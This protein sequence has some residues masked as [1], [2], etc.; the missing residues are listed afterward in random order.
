MSIQNWPELVIGLLGGG[1][2]GSLITFF[3]ARHDN[4]KERAS[5]FYQS[6]YNRLSEYNSALYGF[7]YDFIKNNA[8]ISDSIDASKTNESLIV[9]EVEN[10]NKD[11]NRFVRKCN[12][13]GGPIDDICTQCQKKREK[14]TTLY[15]SSYWETRLDSLKDCAASYS[16][17]AALL[18][19]GGIAKKSIRNAVNRVDVTSVSIIGYRKHD[20]KDEFDVSDV[21]ISQLENINA[22][23]KELS[24]VI[25]N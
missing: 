4:K 1:A 19:S 8:D 16:N 24:Q 2:L 23:L 14:V 17:M 22:A 6:V 13:S 15:Q 7:L 3:I 18:S 20:I 10:L 11:I 9:Q 21:I 12:R 25:K 5:S